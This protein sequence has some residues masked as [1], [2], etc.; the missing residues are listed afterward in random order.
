MALI[1]SIE[2]TT[3]VCSIAISKDGKSLFTEVDNEKN[4]HS[5]KLIS[6]IEAAFAKLKMSLSEL[7]AVAVSHGPGSYTG[8]RIGMSV[9]K[10][11]CYALDKPLISVST[12]HALANAG[13]SQ[14]AL[15][16]SDFFVIPMMD[17]RRMEV[18]M[19]VVNQ[20]MEE[21][22]EVCSLVVE[23]DSFR[24]WLSKPCYFVGNGVSKCLDLLNALENANVIDIPMS[25]EHLIPLAEKA[26]AVNDFVDIAYCEPFYL[27][28][29]IA[30]KPN[31]KGLRA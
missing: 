9:A 6:Y 30:G 27:K 23:P 24:E 18:F 12:L 25:A 29:Y 26:F 20:N 1:L 3:E 16:A 31:V 4:S 21:K 15:A 2:T 8:L 17:A 5:Q 10:A 11:L 19:C 13:I 22:L 7:D 14:S 28:E